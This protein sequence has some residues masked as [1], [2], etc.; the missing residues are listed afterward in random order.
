MTKSTRTR[1]ERD[2]MGEV[3]V[4]DHAL[5]GASTQRAV[6]NFPI[7]GLRLPDEF[8]QSLALIK[9][10]ASRVNQS[11]GLISKRKARAIQ[12]AL[13]EIVDGK[14]MDQFVVDVFQTGS[15]T[16]TNMNMNEVVARRSRFI[17]RTD[18]D[19]RDYIHPNNHVN[20]SQSSND[21]IPSAL[22]LSA[23][24]LTKNMLLPAL[25]ELAR[26]LAKKARK[27]KNTVKSGR[28]HLQDATPVTLGQEF[29]G[30]ASQIRE[31]R[32]MISQ[33]ANNLSSLA[34]G[35]TAVGTGINSPVGFGKAVCSELSEHI[36]VTVK[37]TK[38][39]FRSQSTIDDVVAFSGSLKVLAVALIKITNDLRWMASGPNDGLSEIILPEV[40]PGSSIMP[41]KVNP[42]I[43]ES[44]QQVAV[45]V[46]GADS[47]ITVAGQSGNFELNVMLPVVA[48]NLLNSIKLLANTAANMRIKCIDGIEAN[49]KALASVEKNCSLVTALAPMIGYDQAARIS[50]IAQKTG[51]SVFEIALQ[52]TDLGEDEL[53]TVLDP[54]SMTKPG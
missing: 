19:D 27:F 11:S 16:S 8:I 31:A 54:L 30:Y 14:L 32:K 29:S 7:S 28:T 21:V 33:A 5:Y 44:A 18:L 42:V 10:C 39:H 23:L 25:D 36:D 50:K 26:A 34:I 49:K 38:N 6:D 20:L 15:G 35:G 12:K 24:L 3:L 43:L 9:L 4:P 17:L 2:S 22:N 41:G 48:Y 52:E 53:V 45:Q 47:T 51:K 46:I 13:Q 40:Q 1:I 37:E